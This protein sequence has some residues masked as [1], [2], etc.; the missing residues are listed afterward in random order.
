MTSAES[1]TNMAVF[2]DVENVSDESAT[3]RY[4]TERI[5]QTGSVSRMYAFADWDSRRHMAEEL[6]SLG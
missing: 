4:M 2:W 6:Y 5:K 1:S 3:H